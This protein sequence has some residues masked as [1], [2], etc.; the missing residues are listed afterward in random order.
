M[1]DSQT[2]SSYYQVPPLYGITTV[3][4]VTV[5]ALL[6]KKAP[7]MNTL[8][9]IVIGLLVGYIFVLF[10]NT[11]F[12]SINATLRDFKQFLYFQYLNSHDTTGYIY[13]YPPL[14]VVFIIFVILL[15]NRNI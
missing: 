7:Q 14:L 11:I 10:M 3:I 2:T 15:Y 13:V 1:S 6:L 12:P 9:V 5:V 4:V 8:V